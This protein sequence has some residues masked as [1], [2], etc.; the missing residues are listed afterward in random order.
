[1]EVITAKYPKAPRIADL[2]MAIMRRDV[3]LNSPLNGRVFVG[4][5]KTIGSEARRKMTLE[6]AEKLS[7]AL[8]ALVPNGN[9]PS[10]RDLDSPFT[11]ELDKILEARIS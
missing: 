9:V 10:L 11:D 2:G 6:V 5:E 8:C 1:M 7:Y 4:D 3:Y